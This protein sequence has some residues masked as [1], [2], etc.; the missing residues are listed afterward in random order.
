[1]G[2]PPQDPARWLL[3][4]L[5]VG[6]RP[7]PEIKRT[8]LQRGWPWCPLKRRHLGLSVVSEIGIGPNGK[9][10]WQWRLA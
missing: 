3:E 8:V 6:P 9:L 1:V 2:T 7:V 5:A 4:L 10:Q